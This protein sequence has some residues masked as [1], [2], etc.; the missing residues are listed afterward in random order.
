V[1]VKTFGIQQPAAPLSASQPLQ[2]PA[3][4]A[5]EYTTIGQRAFSNNQKRIRRALDEL[6][7]GTASRAFTE[8]TLASIG[9]STE[10]IT[11]LIDDALEDEVTDD[12]LSEIEAA[13]SLKAAGKYDGID[14]TPPAG[15]R[16]EAKKGLEWRRE[17]N[18]GGTAV[19]VARA[20]NLSNGDAMSP[21]TIGRM[22]SY[23]ARHEVDKKGQGW[24]PGEDGF[25]S[26]G[27]IAWALWG[28]DAGAAWANKVSRQMDARDDN[29]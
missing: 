19:G 13:A 27:R 11:A 8:Q 1:F 16:S 5:G 25:P 24:S 12:E 4:A 17:Y 22:V 3:Q 21:E 6:T 28:G 7:E 18:R 9:L 26:A 23:F 10:R 15:V 29:E 2:A 20:R 14:F